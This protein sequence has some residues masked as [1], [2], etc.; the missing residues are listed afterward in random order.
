MDR[1]EQKCGQGLFE[2]SQIRTGVGNILGESNLAKLSLFWEDLHNL[3]K[4][5]VYKLAS[6]DKVVNICSP[7]LSFLLVFME[8]EQVR[9]IFVFWRK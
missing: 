2:A 4:I 3:Y 9:C 7:K 1:I 8:Q 6:F 5:S